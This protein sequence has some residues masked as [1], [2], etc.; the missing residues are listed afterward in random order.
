MSDIPLDD[1]PE[2]EAWLLARWLEKDQL[3]DQ[4]FETGRFPTALAGSIEAES[5]PKKQKI[6][7]ADGYA[8]TPVRLGHWTEVAQIFAPL[9]GIAVACSIFGF[10]DALLSHYY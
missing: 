7:A 3:L 1:Q 10:K 9:V 4:C 5:V 6:A 2:F 8:E